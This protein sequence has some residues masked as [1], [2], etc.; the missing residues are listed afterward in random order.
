MKNTLVLGLLMVLPVLAGGKSLQRAAELLGEGKVDE[1]LAMYHTLTEEEPENGVAWMH[2][3]YAQK[4]LGHFEKAAAAYLK[5]DEKGF[6][7]YLARYQAGLCYAQ[8]GNKDLAF[9]WL[10]NAVNSGFADLEQLGSEKLLNSLRP[11]AR[12]ADLMELADRKAHPC[13]FDKAYNALDFWVGS[14]HLHDAFGHQVGSSEIEKDQAGCIITERFEG[15]FG[16][17]NGFSIT[18]FDQKTQKWHQSFTSKRGNVSIWEGQVI[19]GGVQF[20]RDN[21]NAQGEPI[22]SRMTIALEKGVVTQRVENSSDK[23]KSWSLGWEGHYTPHPPE[24]AS[25]TASR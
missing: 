6:A 5:A 9:T 13:R 15:R 23:G 10:T 25:T 7:S 11:D 16:G 8:A 20:L 3:A 17:G 18:M 1:G 14:W 21:V 19:E 12:F 4:S 22:L 2:L 24:A